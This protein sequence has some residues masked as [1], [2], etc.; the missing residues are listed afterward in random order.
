MCECSLVMM[1]DMEVTPAA[2]EENVVV[3]GM[4]CGDPDCPLPRLYRLRHYYHEC[5]RD[6]DN[7]IALYN[8]P[9]GQGESA[10]VLD[11]AR[12]V[13]RVTEAQTSSGD[14]LEGIWDE[15]PYTVSGC[16]KG[17][18]SRTGCD[19]CGH[20]RG[21]GGSI[22]CNY[23]GTAVNYDHSYLRQ[24]IEFRESKIIEKRDE[25]NSA[26]Q[27]LI[28]ALKE[29]AVQQHLIDGHS[30]E[31]PPQ[32]QVPL[33][34]YNISDWAQE[35]QDRPFLTER[36]HVLAC[37][38]VRL[39]AVEA[40]R[41][42][43]G[44]LLD[45]AYVGDGVQRDDYKAV[46]EAWK[47]FTSTVKASPAIGRFFANL[48][49]VIVERGR[50][51]ILR[52]NVSQ[53]IRRQQAADPIGLVMRQPGIRQIMSFLDE[54]S[55]VD[56]SEEILRQARAQGNRADSFLQQAHLRRN[57]ISAMDE[58]EG[59]QGVTAQK[60]Q[61]AG[62]QIGINLISFTLA[63]A[64]LLKD[65][66]NQGVKDWLGI[67]SGAAGVADA[68]LQAVESCGTGGAG[69]MTRVQGS[70]LTLSRL[71][72]VIQV[73][74]ASMDIADA[75]EDREYDATAIHSV[76]L[77]AG[78]TGSTAALIATYGPGMGVALATTAAATMVAGVCFVVA[79]VCVII[80]ILIADH[81]IV[82]YLQKT[83]WGTDGRYTIAQTIDKYYEDLYQDDFHI[84]F[85]TSGPGD[86]HLI[87]RSRA[88][89]DHVPVEITNDS[90]PLS[91][92]RSLRVFPTLGQGNRTILTSTGSLNWRVQCVAHPSGGR[93]LQVFD[94]SELYAI[95]LSSE[96][97]AKM[98]PDAD[99]EYEL[100]TDITN[101]R[102]F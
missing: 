17:C 62:F 53:R 59:D 100:T 45:S 12:F 22:S 34:C 66:E 72:H 93:E 50:A 2:E 102:F 67:V 26:A 16:M 96:I 97:S 21:R 92:R 24:Y 54:T 25:A 60:L 61:T 51:L 74:T 64:K 44:H 68:S 90:T 31:F 28:N 101:V 10:R 11:M 84:E 75:V 19:A 36:D 37:L 86:P 15:S 4:Q 1:E 88:L 56:F 65:W 40:G 83:H 58:W 70:I 35:A 27:D 98:D 33:I 57:L 79:L 23:G 42:F 71:A 39:E 77:A 9:A 8:P 49:P 73:I 14:P 76:S 91:A 43:L 95:P 80:I 52:G 38:T 89:T 82:D 46:E 55:D 63:M 18:D 32:S 20:A 87:I 47:V 5:L 29:S 85:Q 7:A 81:P 78:L 41:E 13:R 69:G 30:T 6:L 3:T 94:C 99:G 48:S